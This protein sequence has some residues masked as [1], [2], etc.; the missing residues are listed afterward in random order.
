M[1]GNANQEILLGD[2]DIVYPNRIGNLYSPATINSGTGTG[3]LTLVTGNPGYYITEL[4]YHADVTCTLASAGMISITF[5][6]SSSGTVA[7]FRLYVPAAVTAPGYA[8][9]IRQ[10]NQG[11]FVW[12]SKVASSTLSVSINTALTAGS[13]RCFVRYGTTSYLG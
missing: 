6:D 5:M 10:V 2:S 8:T 13:I 12:S 9:T 4:G 1:A 7:N 3:S 11:P